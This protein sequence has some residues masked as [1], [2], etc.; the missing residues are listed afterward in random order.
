MVLLELLA[1]RGRPVHRAR[2]VHRDLP[3]R[4]VLPGLSG[5]RVWPVL[6]VLRDPQDLLVPW[7]C[8]G[9]IGPAGPAGPPGPAGLG[10]VLQAG[11]SANL[12]PADNATYYYGCFPSIAAATSA[13][14][15]A[16]NRCYLPR[17]GTITAVVAHFWDA[18]TL[19]SA[20]PSTISLRL[21]GVSTTPVTA[22]VLNNAAST[23]FSNT[24]LSIPVA[25]GDYLQVLWSTP[26]WAPN[27]TNVR[28]AVV[29]YVQ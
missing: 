20:Q 3:V 19:A 24:G 14:V 16:N 23:V 15:N 4:R 13:A 11:S 27:P 26:V 21:N 8:R 10:Y 22:A 6:P 9:P 12:N 7:G 29:V 28:L 1:L 5:P 25:A 17:A 2:L 18:G